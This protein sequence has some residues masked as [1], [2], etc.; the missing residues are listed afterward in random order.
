MPLF[1]HIGDARKE[2]AFVR[3]GIVPGARRRG[4]EAGVYAMPL[5]S[6]YFVSHQWNRELKRG[7]VRKM[8]GVHFR[9]P[10]RQR[11]WIGHY[12]APHVEMTAARATRVIMDAKDARG[13]EVII[14]RKILPKEIHA[15]RE[16]NDVVG[17][18]Y[19]PDAHG[20]Y[21]CGCPVCVPRGSIK[22]RRLRE[23]FEAS[24]DPWRTQPASRSK[25]PGMD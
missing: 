13:Y 11:V 7:G 1:V 20:K 6:S 9:V 21:L 19:Y 22:G 17:W 4:V 16:V 23:K 5:L 8:I 3:S 15:V 14:P 12:N 24:Q 10:D 25:D 18:R 2:K